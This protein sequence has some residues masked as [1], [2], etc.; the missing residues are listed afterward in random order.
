MAADDRVESDSLLSRIVRNEWI[1]PGLFFIAVGTA[2]LIISRDYPL[3]NLTRMGPGFFPRMLSFAMIGL[4]VL[5]VLKGVAGLA[6]VRALDFP[7]RRFDRSIVLIP[8]AMAVFG[9]A[10]EPLGLVA[11][12]TLSIAVAGVAHRQA[13]L[14]EVAASIV[15]LT[16]LSFVIFIWILKLPLRVWPSL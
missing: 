3:G 1:P 5:I 9:L 12:L 14:K 15:F 11:A 7:R 10:I 16:T 4:G 13:S 8:A 6:A 2:A